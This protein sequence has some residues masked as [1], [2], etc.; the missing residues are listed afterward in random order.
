MT[1]DNVKQTRIL[2]V[3]DEPMIALDLQDFLVDAG[4]EVVAVAGRLD[5]A[6]ALIEN[7]DVDV[8][9]V[10]ANLAGVSASPA[11]AAL[12]TRGVPFVVLSGYSLAQQQDAFPG[13]HF[14]QKPCRPA[15]LIDALN[16]LVL[17]G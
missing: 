13:G 16:H 12:V 4:F 2:I 3:E 7:V 8:A 17:K 10:D 5:K 11:A 14:L 6:L 1:V 9:V 15:R